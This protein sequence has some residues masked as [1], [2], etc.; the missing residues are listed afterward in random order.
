MLKQE[1]R[2]VSITAFHFRA[3]AVHGAVAGDAGV[4]DQHVDRPESKRRRLMPV[5]VL[6]LLRGARSL[7]T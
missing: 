3:H 4:V 7:P 5:S 6:E 2:L 1:P